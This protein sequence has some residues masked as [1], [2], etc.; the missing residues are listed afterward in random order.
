MKKFLLLL[1]VILLL[2]PGVL[3]KE[4]HLKLLAVQEGK[5]LTGSDAD[6]YLELKPGSGRV[7]LDT[8]PTPKLDTQISTRFAKEIACKQYDLRCENYD[9]IF[10]IQ[11][12]S[13][14]IGGP[15]A[16]AAIAAL[17][18]IAM[19]DMPYREDIT[20]TGTINP[21]GIVGPVGGVHEK[22]QAASKA[23]ISK[24][25]VSSG[26][27]G[28]ATSKVWGRK[29]SLF[30]YVGMNV[31]EVVHLDEVLFHITGENVSQPILDLQQPIAY[32][33][34]MSNVN[35]ILCSR[36]GELFKEISHQNIDLINTTRI[37]IRDKL[38]KSY[39][40]TK[41]NDLYSSASFCFG[42]NIELREVIYRDYGLSKV[43]H[44]FEQIMREASAVGRM[45]NAQPLN[46]I[47]D[48]Q[49]KMI[50]KERLEDVQRSVTNY[51]KEKHLWS[52]NQ[53]IK[54]LGYAKERL[55][56]AR[57]WTQFFA[58]EGKQFE[59][60]AQTLKASCE[61]KIMEA[62]QRY[63]Y[64]A[65]FVRSSILTFIREK[66]DS[67]TA[68]LHRNEYELCLITA[69]QAKAD[70]NVVQS[71]IGQTNTS[72][73]KYIDAKKRAAQRV[74]SKNSKEGIFPILGYSY[75]QYAN[76][77]EP[78]SALLYVEYA[79]EM[80]QIDIYFQKQDVFSWKKFIPS[81]RERIFLAEGFLIGLLFCVIISAFRKK[82]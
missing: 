45:V 22:L 79:L 41:A 78:Y 37:S 36:T 59:V 47:S 33:T 18:T 72:I 66:I 20:I 69:I 1:V 7:F 24:V 74:I 50:V 51:H 77:L 15:S 29:T 73:Q 44:E 27:K 10:T 8:N 71:S 16:G 42:A 82:V 75:F 26:A 56:T 76:S 3:A 81:S 55:F 5:I 53:S 2:L 14:I 63:E 43:N 68:A 17:T 38:A 60:D 70:A 30:D 23:G 58:M 61:S 52:L 31:V 6:L 34:I 25:L 4:Y 32:T 54:T 48:L 19:R 65:L 57:V 21:G 40:A 64:V 13:S 62:R 80:S 46:T 11:A 9:F 49:A 67:S 28:N 35:D 39:N 12:R